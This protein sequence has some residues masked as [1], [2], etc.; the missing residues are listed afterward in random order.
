[1]SPL[2]YYKCFKLTALHPF[3]CAVFAAGFGTRAYGAFHDDD[4]QVFTASI[5]LLFLAP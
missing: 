2:S 1:M 5:L 3:S 4:S